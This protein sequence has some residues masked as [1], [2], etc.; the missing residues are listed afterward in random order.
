MK[1]VESV[2]LHWTNG[3][4]N[5]LTGKDL[6]AYVATEVFHGLRSGDVELRK[7]AIK[8]DEKECMRYAKSLVSNHFKKAKEI[9]GGIKYTPAT[10]RGPI[11]KDEMLRELG[12][13]L[14]ALKSMSEPDMNLITAVE[15]AIAQRAG[16]VEEVKKAKSAPSIDDIKSKLE[17]LG[18]V[19]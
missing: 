13:N 16:Q 11:V 8:E 18:V 17:A 3:T 7:A 15:A 6:E 12:K 1:Q 5:G 2:I 10:T 9:N 14:K 19:I 4:N